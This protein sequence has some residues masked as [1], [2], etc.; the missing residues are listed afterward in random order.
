MVA[1]EPDSACVHAQCLTPNG[2]IVFKENMT[3]DTGT[4]FTVDLDDSSVT[5]SD[6]YF[7]AI[8]QLA[9]LEVVHTAHQ[10]MWPV[11]LLPVQMYCVAP[12]QIVGDDGE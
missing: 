2:V 5:R 11:D 4:A 7:R 1:M 3:M 6:A 8:F 9:G 12:P 10:V